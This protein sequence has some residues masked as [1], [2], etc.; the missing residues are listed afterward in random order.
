MLELEEIN[1]KFRRIEGGDNSALREWLNHDISIQKGFHSILQE[2]KM[3]FRSW[4]CNSNRFLK[5]QEEESIMNCI[6]QLIV[7]IVEQPLV[8]DTRLSFICDI[9]GLSDLKFK[10]TL[11]S[12]QT[13]G[14][15]H[16]YTAKLSN[17]LE[18]FIPFNFV[19]ALYSTIRPK[20]KIILKYLLVQLLR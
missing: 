14:P 5:I 11:N 2:F 20:Y 4:I 8:N 7:K 1:N 18:D 13:M 3:T 10:S 15:L 16:K 12:R 17:K 6:G 19:V 9:L